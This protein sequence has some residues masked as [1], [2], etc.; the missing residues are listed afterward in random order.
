MT[1]IKQVGNTVKAA[2]YHLRNIN[3][4]RRSLNN[5]TCVLA[6]LSLV[7]KSSISLKIMDSSSEKALIRRV[8]ERIWKIKMPKTIKKLQEMGHDLFEWLRE[9]VSLE[10]PAADPLHCQATRMRNVVGVLENRLLK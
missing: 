1:M 7:W 6:V 2:Y 9:T 3:Y 4:A 5:D 8:R 10:L